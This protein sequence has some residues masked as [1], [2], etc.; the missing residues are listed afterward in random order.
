MTLGGLGNWA[1]C[2]IPKPELRET[3]GV[4]KIKRKKYTWIFLNF[5]LSFI[6]CVNC[7]LRYLLYLNSE[8]PEIL[9]MLAVIKTLQSID[10]LQ[11]YQKYMLVF[12]IVALIQT[13]K[14]NASSVQFQL[15][16]SMR[17]NIFQIAKIYATIAIKACL[18][19]SKK[20]SY[21]RNI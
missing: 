2:N 7:W 5:V 1:G 14:F 13:G 8:W 17:N 10:F 6:F 15:P 16:S 12:S 21:H 11:K 18:W 9:S 4:S 19:K 3:K 20:F